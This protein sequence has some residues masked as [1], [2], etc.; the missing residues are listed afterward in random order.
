MT[1]DRMKK[2]ADEVVAELVRLGIVARSHRGI[3]YDVVR[4]AFERHFAPELRGPAH[5]ARAAEG[6]VIDASTP[7][8]VCPDGRD[9]A[10]CPKCQEW[11]GQSHRE[12]E[13]L[14]WEKAQL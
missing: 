6:D 3:S 1:E 7:Q 9:W 13:W 10:S 8:A 5:G 4:H 14:P 12:P 2:Y 11:N